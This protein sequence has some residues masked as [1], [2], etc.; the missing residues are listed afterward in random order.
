MDK[1]KQSSIEALQEAITLLGGQR[2]LAV[3]LGFDPVKGGARVNAWTKDGVPG[4]WAIPIEE[5]TGGK[6]SRT[7]LAPQLYPPE[8]AE[9]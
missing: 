3:A 5:K 2:K 4:K 7:R 1:N 8:K 9:A 6:I